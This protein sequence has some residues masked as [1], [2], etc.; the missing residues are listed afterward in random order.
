MA[1]KNDGQWERV[2]LVGVDTG[3]ETDFMV[4]M[5]ELEQLAEAGL[6][7][8]VG[9]MVQNLEAFHSSLY[10]GTGK[11]VEIAQAAEQLD[12][13]TI[14]FYDPLSP[15]QLRNLQK[16]IGRPVMDRT[17][18]ILDIFDKRAVS[19]EAKLQVETARL[20]Y[21]LPRLVGMHEALTRQ[22]GAS[23]SQSSRGA[24][25]KKLELDRRK[26][27]NRITELKAE[28]KEVAANREVQ[29]KMRTSSTLPLVSLV[30]YTNAG[31]S[32][33]MNAMVDTYMQDKDK[34]VLEKD[35]LF[36]TLETTIRRIKTGQ[37]QEWL[38]S[39]T[40]GFIHKLPTGLIKAFHATLEEIKNADLL[41]HVVD[42]SDEH[43][44][45]HMQVTLDTLK[46]LGAAHIPMITIYN[47]ADKCMADYPTIKGNDRIFLSAK[48][49]AGLSELVGMI[50]EAVTSDH[51]A[52]DFLIPYCESG[53]ESYF[54]EHAIVDKKEYLE[55]GIALSVR[56][57]PA[58]RDRYGWYVVDR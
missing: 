8:T 15:S 33:I 5:E 25:E 17:A 7:E 6:M 56:C 57:R 35:M 1:I 41:L 10:V 28:L 49:R 58:D 12:A 45:E 44:Q 50:T 14:V 34:L 51:V 13:D 21:L 46:E 19:R 55:E 47:K 27:S 2:I 32:T 52:V 39:D 3:A 48:Q 29:R 53:I 40:V 38:L 18:L 4:G 43:Y 16:E 36:A 22:G 23:G 24:G 11:V 26:I 30:G 9:V 37:H 31:K 20:Q 54:I 42:Y